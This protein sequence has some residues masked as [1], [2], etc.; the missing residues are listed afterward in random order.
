MGEFEHI[1]CSGTR[2]YD[3]AIPVKCNNYDSQKIIVHH[4]IDTAIDALLESD[5]RKYIISN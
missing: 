1:I 4:D 2:A 3:M 5:N